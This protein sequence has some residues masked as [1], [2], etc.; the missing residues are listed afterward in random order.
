MRK[1]FSAM[2]P[3]LTWSPRMPPTTISVGPWAKSS[4]TGVRGRGLPS[5]RFAR[6]L[7][8]SLFRDPGV[9]RNVEVGD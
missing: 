6:W 5:G 2:T 3:I 9:S 4:P 7:N 1:R 8:L